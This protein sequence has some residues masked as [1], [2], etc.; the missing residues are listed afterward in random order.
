M[1]GNRGVSVDLHKSSHQRTG[2]HKNSI[3]QGAQ[4]EKKGFSIET[5]DTEGAPNRQTARSKQ[6]S[7]SEQ[8]PKKGGFKKA[9]KHLTLLEEGGGQ[10]HHIKDPEQKQTPHPKRTCLA[11]KK[12][13]KI[14]RKPTPILT[15]LGRDSKNRPTNLNH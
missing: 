5:K 6:V 14:I 8:Q 2:Q 1:G 10:Y 7:T 9:K 15:N 11:R 3:P 4:G 13:K 12:S